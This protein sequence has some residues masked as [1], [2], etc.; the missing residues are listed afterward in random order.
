M[1]IDA[2][3]PRQ[4]PAL[5][6]LWKQAFGD[7]DGYLDSFFCLAFSPERCRCIIKDGAP[8]AVLYWFDC[9]WEDKR[10]AYIYAVATDKV[11]QGQGLCR[12]LM[13]NT[14]EHLKRLGYDG[15]I[16]VPG[17]SE[18]FRLYEKLG[19]TTCAYIREFES[20]ASGEAIPLQ[21]LDAEEYALCR[22]QMLPPGGVIQ[23]GETLSLLAAQSR[24]YAGERC[25]LVCAQGGE[26]LVVSEL[27]GDADAVPGVLAALGYP[28]GKVRAP[29][30]QKPFAMYRSLTDDPAAPKYF[31]LAM[32]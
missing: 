7:T 28:R 10:L 26:E 27:L 18:L 5:R 13:E 20:K 2:P 21:P 8:A 9:A 15:C 30:G 14:H 25:L 31:G 6:A 16:L 29:G 4:I 3:D 32:D 11:H 19:Y 24:F 1:I 12:T 23:E 22:R 17:S